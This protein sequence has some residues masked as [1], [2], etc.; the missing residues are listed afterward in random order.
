MAST[1]LPR[2]SCIVYILR[3]SDRSDPYDV[4][5]PAPFYV[6]IGKPNRPYF[7]FWWARHTKANTHKLNIIRAVER[8]GG[9]I[10]V[11]CVAE[12]IDGEVAGSIERQLIHFYGRHNQGGLLANQTDGGEG[13][14]GLSPETRERI[15]QANLGKKLSAATIERLRK[16]RVGFH[17]SEATKIKLGDLGRGRKHSPEAIAK[18][19]VAVQQALARG[20]KPAVLTPES[21]A[22]KIASLTGRKYPEMGLRNRGG[23]NPVARGFWVDDQYYGCLKDAAKALG[24]DKTTI[25]RQLQQ[26]NARYR[27][28]PGTEDIGAKLSGSQSATAR[29]ILVNGIPYTTVDE[30]ILRLGI[31]KTT[32]YRRVKNG[33]YRIEYPEQRKD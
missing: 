14:R 12:G 9:V 5:L 16:A 24:I 18:M 8:D 26:G 28:A 27:Y 30:A 7:H 32:F 20:R 15:R 21:L 31:G 25:Y 6:G 17:H 33:A 13:V 23:G 4:T 19:S 1:S 11:E 22:H 3:R 29:A 2:K 10:S